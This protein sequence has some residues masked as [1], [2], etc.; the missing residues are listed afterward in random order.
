LVV[1]FFGADLP[2]L[3]H[4]ARQQSIMQDR[5]HGS[6]RCTVA[7]LPGCVGAL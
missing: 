2:I 5:G 7:Y 1:Y 3:Q 6:I 4:S